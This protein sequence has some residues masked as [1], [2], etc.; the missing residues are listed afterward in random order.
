VT[1]TN[2]VLST[3]LD[4]TLA[5]HAS[6]STTPLAPSGT[7]PPPL[8]GTRL[9]TW[10]AHPLAWVSLSVVTAPHD[11]NEDVAKCALVNSIAGTTVLVDYTTGEELG[12]KQIGEKES[13]PGTKSGWAEP[14]SCVYR[15]WEPIVSFCL[16]G[17][18]VV[19]W[20]ISLCA[21]GKTYASTGA[22]G[23]ITI[24][25]VGSSSSD[26]S[27]GD[28]F[29]THLAH[30]PSG[31]SKFGLYLDYSPADSSRIAMSNESGQVSG[32]KR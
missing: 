22:S 3:S 31:R 20:A 27:S 8:P 26:E 21:D 17:G 16:F 6:S 19:A 29:G 15:L 10:P 9:R 11:Q 18:L 4:G 7:S 12:R 13:G 28:A 25:S 2:D 1:C 30:V 24:H 14:G 23:G 32:L 5:L